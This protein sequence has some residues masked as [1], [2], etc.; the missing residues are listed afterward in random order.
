MFC[1]YYFVWSW[2]FLAGQMSWNQMIP[3]FDC[4]RMSLFFLHVWSEFLWLQNSRLVRV[5]LSKLCS[6][7]FSSCL[8]LFAEET[9][10]N[11]FF[12]VSKVFSHLDSFRVFFFIFHFLWFEHYFP[13]CYV[14]ILFFV[15]FAFI[16]LGVKF[17]I[18]LVFFF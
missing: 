14:F 2:R 10:Y 13:H 7:P 18:S 5:C 3:S 16:L 8:Q 11:S 1:W 9:C 17:L 6:G 12:P 15:L 4:L